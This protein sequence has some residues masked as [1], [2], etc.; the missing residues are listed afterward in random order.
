MIAFLLAASILAVASFLIKKSNFLSFYRIP[1]ALVSSIPL[2]ILFSFFTDWKEM[3]FY[4]EWKDWPG[5]TIALV[6]A[7]LFLE[8]P[9]KK[10]NQGSD[11]PPVL[12]QTSLVFIAIIGQMAV[13]L[14]LTILLFKPIFGLPYAFASVLEAGFAGG[15]GTAV[16]L[17]PTF[18]ANGLN[19]GMEYS[20][21]SATTGIVFGILGGVWIVSRKRRS[22]SLEVTKEIVHAEDEVSGFSLNSFLAGFGLISL[23]VLFGSLVKSLGEKTFPNIPSFPL[24][25]YSLLISVVLRKL[26]QATGQYKYLN[27]SLFTFFSAFFMEFLV[28]SAIVTMDLQVISDALLPLLILFGAGFSWN[29][30]CHFYIRK[31]LL[32]EEYSF[33]LSIINFGMLNGTT[34][35]G[36]MLLK[37]LDPKLQSPAV[38]VFAESAPLTAPFVGGG[39]LSLALPY[40]VTVQNPYLILCFLVGTMAIFGYVGIRAKRSIVA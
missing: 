14:L 34:A 26:L 3:G 38:K 6:F 19:A 16:A 29:L 18:K 23:A 24:F 22:Q 28:F 11:F 39:I 7:A 21:F 10:E 13:G 8:V 1:P 37:I 2:L 12:A 5:V 36:L 40:L 35:I 9:E 4:K 27:N 15:H 31:K 17:D 20:L 25:V 30:I 32:P 33:E